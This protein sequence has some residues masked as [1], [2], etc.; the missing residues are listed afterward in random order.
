MMLVILGFDYHVINIAFHQMMYQITK[1][2]RHSTLVRC[3]SILQ[4][5]RHDNVVE[6]ALRGPKSG[7]DG[8]IG[9]HLDL[10]V[11]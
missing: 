10:V 9:V 8:V 1:N 4:P 7:V 5:K 11:A 3:A 6:V 2:T